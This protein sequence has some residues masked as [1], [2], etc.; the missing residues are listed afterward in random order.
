MKSKKHIALVHHNIMI[1][2]MIFCIKT[3]AIACMTMS[4][5]YFAIDTLR[6]LL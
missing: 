3:F 1:E 5:T 2:G 6:K 4:I